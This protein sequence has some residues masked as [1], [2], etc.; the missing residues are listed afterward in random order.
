[1][2]SSVT[3]NCQATKIV[4][5]SVYQLSELKSVSQMSQVKIV[6]L[7]KS[8]HMSRMSQISQMSQVSQMS[9][10]SQLSQMS[11]V[12][13]MLVGRYFFGQVMSP[14]L[15]DQIFKGHKSLVLLFVCQK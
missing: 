12:S 13:Q 5:N 11:Q 14:E 2:L 9:Q 4:M 15:S 10:M 1:M 6:K 7:S 8:S 3:L